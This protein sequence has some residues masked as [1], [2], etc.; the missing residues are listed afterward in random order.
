MSLTYDQLNVG[1]ASSRENKFFY[2]PNRVEAATEELIIILK[3]ITFVR[4]SGVLIDEGGCETGF[5]N[6]RNQN[7]NF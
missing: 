2:H 5:I 7:S 1:A 4:N 6:P 3:L